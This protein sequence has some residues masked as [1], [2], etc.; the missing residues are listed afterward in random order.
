[1]QLHEFSMGDVED[2]DIYVAQPIYEW[3]QTKKGKWCMENATNL[4]YWTNP[5]P[6]TFGYKI[7]ITGDMEDKIA[8]EFKLRF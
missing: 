5:D 2:V 1:M 4:K 7:R 8:F 3:Q 6:Y